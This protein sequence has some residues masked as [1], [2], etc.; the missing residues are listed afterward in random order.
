MSSFMPHANVQAHNKIRISGFSNFLSYI[1]NCK[2]LNIRLKLNCTGVNCALLKVDSAHK[3]FCKEA[4]LLA[5]KNNEFAF[6][7]SNHD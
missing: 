2:S 7:E 6:N 4:H 1:K 5:S 3:A